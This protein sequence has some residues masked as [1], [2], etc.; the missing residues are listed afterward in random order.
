[1]SEFVWFVV[2]GVIGLVDEVGVVLCLMMRYDAI[3]LSIGKA[4]A[5]GSSG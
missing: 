1:V 3:Q 2:S 4:F 5:A